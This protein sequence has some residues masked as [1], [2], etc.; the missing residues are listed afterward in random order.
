V[1]LDGVGGSPWVLLLRDDEVAP[2]GLRDAIGGAIAAG[3]PRRIRRELHALGEVFGVVGAPLR[4]AARAGSRV[5]VRRGTEL[6]LRVS[7]PRSALDPL[8]PALVV[9]HAESLEDALEALDADSTTAAALLD[10]GGRSARLR[11]LLLAPCVAAGRVLLARV[12]RSV[13]LARWV[14][15]VLVGYGAVV[16]HAKL[17]ERV[18][19]RPLRIA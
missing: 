3:E 10:L 17:W 1:A 12:P 13:G 4:F 16:A 6:E 7:A 11:D 15:A 5:D 2:P 18:R 14:V 19:N 8:G 9:V